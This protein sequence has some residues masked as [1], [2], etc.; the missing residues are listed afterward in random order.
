VK[1]LLQLQQEEILEEHWHQVVNDGLWF[2]SV[3]LVCDPHVTCDRITK[4]DRVSEGQG[5]R[6][7]ALVQ[8]CIKNTGG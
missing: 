8:S 7:D 4:W 6:D 2:W 1:L 3:V 5:M